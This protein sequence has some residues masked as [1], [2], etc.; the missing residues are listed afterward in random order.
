MTSVVTMVTMVTGA[1]AVLFLF[2]QQGA[3]LD[4]GLARLPPMGWMSSE[5]FG[6]NVN[7]EDYPDDCI[8]YMN[9]VE[10]PW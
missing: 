6:C 10:L 4:N 2:I 9:N 7:C 8:R 5:R 3:A 1:L